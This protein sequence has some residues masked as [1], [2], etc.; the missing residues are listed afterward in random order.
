MKNKGLLIVLSG[1][2]GAGKDTVIDR[3]ISNDGS[4]TRLISAT[5]RAP[6]PSEINGIDYFFISKEEFCKNISAGK[7]LEYTKYCENYYGTL[8][9]SVEEILADGQ[10]V[11]LKIEVDGARQI[12]EK[13]PDSLRIFILPPT[14]QELKNRL[15]NRGSEPYKNLEIRL[16]RA[17]EEIKFSLQYDY[18]VVNDTVDECAA[19]INSIVNAEKFKPC[20]MKNIVNEVLN[21][22]KNTDRWYIGRQKK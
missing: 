21:D 2:S 19:A 20:R 16:K 7:L 13:C 18:I 10:N 11:I 8:K 9:K 22:E 17:I 5:T 4:I 15:L 14:M 1:P 12:K 3:V 6:R